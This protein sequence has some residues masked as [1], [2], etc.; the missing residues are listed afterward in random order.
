MLPVCQ[1]SNAS[2]GAGSCPVLPRPRTT[3]SNHHY[4][5]PPP[6]HHHQATTTP[7]TTATTTA[8]TAAISIFIMEEFGQKLLHL[9]TTRTRNLSSCLLLGFLQNCRY[10]CS[11][12]G[13]KPRRPKIRPKSMGPATHA[14]YSMAWVMPLMLP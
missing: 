2:I 10:L 9:S 7:T 1:C 3:G 8:T 11:Q 6:S 4:T 13:K 5:P 14:A 12:C